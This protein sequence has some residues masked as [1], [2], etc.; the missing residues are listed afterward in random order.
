MT[1]ALQPKP[2]SQRTQLPELRRRRSTLRGFGHTLTVVC[3][4]CLRILDAKDPNL[5]ILQKFEAQA[6]HQAADPARRARQVGRAPT[7]K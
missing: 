6:A 1:P 3:P 5:Q 2:P 7:T 4:Q